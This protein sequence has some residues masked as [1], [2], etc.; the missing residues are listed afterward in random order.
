MPKYWLISDRDKGG[1]GTGRNVSGLNYFVSDNSPLNKIENW[2]KVSPKQFRTLLAR[3]A[4]LLA[5]IR[6]D[7]M[8]EWRKIQRLPER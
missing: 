4:G 5:G 1:T 8:T 2:K 3:E 7:T 6:H